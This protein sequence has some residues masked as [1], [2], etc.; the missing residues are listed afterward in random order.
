EDG[1]E[2]RMGGKE[3]DSVADFPQAP[4]ASGDTGPMGAVWLEGG[5]PVTACPNCQSRMSIRLW[6][7]SAECPR[8]SL[9]IPLSEAQVQQALAL[10]RGTAPA[11]GEAT[12]APVPQPI[13]IKPVPVTGS[14]AAGAIPQAPHAVPVV[15]HI[16]SALAAR[17]RRKAAPLSP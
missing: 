3:T 17:P 16:S 4:I 5:K 13:Q 10:S 1:R 11:A 9:T 15:P 2:Y 6:L 12:S 14:G 8:C 7:S